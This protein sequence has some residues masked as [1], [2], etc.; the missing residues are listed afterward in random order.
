MLGTPTPE[1]MKYIGIIFR[2]IIGNENA[3]KYIKSLPKRTKQSWDK[4]F[5]NIKP[6]AADLLSKMLTFNPDKRYTV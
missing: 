3:I 5:P 2:Y 1:D 6:Q 4:L